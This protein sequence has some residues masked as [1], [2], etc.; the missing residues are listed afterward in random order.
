MNKPNPML[1]ELKKI[2][3]QIAANAVTAEQERKVP[4]ANIHLLKSIQLHR[5]LQPKAYG[6]LELSLPEVA[7]CVAALAGA[8]GGTAWAFSLLIT[9]SHQMAM[10]S[11]QA[12]EEFWGENPDAVASSSIAPFGKTEECEGGVIFNGD[13]R[14]SSGCDHAQWAILGFLRLNPETGEKDYSFGVVPASDYEIEDDWYSA[15]MK[16]SGTK[17]L[18]IKENTFIPEHRIEKAKAM[19]TGQSSGFGLYPDS[20]I[21]YAPYRPYFAS[22]FAAMAIGIAERMLTVYK[23]MT[24]NRTRAYTLASSGK[25]IPPIMR[26][27]ESTHQVA[28][29][30]AF[31]EKTWDEHKALSEQKRYPTDEELAFW[32]TNQ[33][34]AIKMC[35]EA[36]NRLFEVAGGS[37]WI[38]D[39]EIQRLWRDCNMTAAHA[40]TDYD[41]CK[42]VLGR[43][44]MGMDP[45]PTM[46]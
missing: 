14:W 12:Q 28:A 42:Q 33:A 10:F 41:V 40:Y 21:F 37:T 35:C 31:M 24:K 25:E 29:A 38:H 13:M 22:G 39:N 1:D 7:D 34:Y 27:A 46:V 11:K 44:L 3:P 6:G 18:K 2:L 36:V 30:R 8:C 9:H 16:P 26:L 5:A 17:T 45:D 20:K 19:M 43:S 32:R 4:D 23:E 15:G